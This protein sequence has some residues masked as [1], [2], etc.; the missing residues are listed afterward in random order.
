MTDLQNTILE[1]IARGEPLVKTLVRLCLEVERIA[2]DVICSVVSVD[3]AGCLHS[4][5]APSM[6]ASYSAAL[7]GIPIGA[8]VG[9]CG[10]AAHLV[11]EVVTP[12]IAADPDWEGYRHLVLPLGLGACWSSPIKDSRGAVVGCFGFYFREARGPS[13]TER[14]IVNQCLNLCSIAIDRHR[15]VVERERR[16]LTDE[17]T[18]LPNR[19]AFNAALGELD[20]DAPGT[21]AICLLDL[22][23]LKVVNDTFGHQ[24]GD[25]LL[26]HVAQR[27]ARVARPER[28]YRVGGDEFAIV[29][30]R[31]E[32]LADLEKLAETYLAALGGV[33][34][35]AGN[36]VAPRATIGMAVVAVGDRVAERVR[37]NA[38]FALYHAKET[39]RGGFVRYWPGIGTRM[40]RRLTAIRE[41]DAALR[42]GRIIAHYQPVIRLETGGIVGVEALCRMRLGNKLI[43]A[44][45]FHEATTDAHIAS[46]LTEQMLTHV[47]ADLRTW[48]DMGIPFQHVGVNV[49]SA[50]FHRGGIMPILARTF[51]AQGVPLQHIVL[52]VTE[53]VYMGDDAGVVQRA[54]AEL[55]ERGVRVALDDFGTGYA[56][57]THLMSV[58][59][60][61]IKIDK[62]F[63]DRIDV[64]GPS[65]AIVEGVVGIAAKL[66]MG[67][68]AEGIETEA[69]SRLLRDLGCEL[70]QGHLYSPAIPGADAG[71]IML[72]RAEGVP[73]SGNERRRTI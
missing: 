12:D 65:Q 45:A 16:A 46:A 68:V 61:Y 4:L 18:S 44:A 35:C 63:V 56:S 55:R 66:G 21:W 41:V 32:A 57:L 54:V 11:R 3:E 19:A 28:V 37:Q 73:A 27:L 71:A 8:Q 5:A 40:T 62:S 22:D 49:S 26:V 53:S 33:A 6:P 31:P 59:V 51:E 47:A 43:S 13:R 70:G 2:P 17:L 29:V 30:H 64:H 69:Q 7:D 48:L 25:D 36:V 39:G 38:D 20:C 9:T 15:R 14:E 42:E 1:L 60:D 72:E 23:N 34:D 52:E 10:A 50:D 58:P 24:A 67:I